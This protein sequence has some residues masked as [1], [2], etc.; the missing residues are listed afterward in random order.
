MTE[1]G[2]ASKR[3]CSV[4][5]VGSVGSWVYQMEI[6]GGSVPREV[7]PMIHASKPGDDPAAHAPAQGDAVLPTQEEEEQRRF[8]MSRSL[9]ASPDTPVQATKKRRYSATLFIERDMKKHQKETTTAQGESHRPTV[10]G[11]PAAAPLHAGPEG[12]DVDTE[13]AN[14]PRALKRPGKRSR[15]AQPAAG[16]KEDAP[17]KAPLPQLHGD[18]DSVA[19]EMSAWT[20][21]EIQR[22]LDDLDEREAQTSPV[23]PGTR[24]A[25]RFQPRV[26]AR[27]YPERHP[28]QGDPVAGPPG[29][30]AM[31][32]D[33]AQ[34]QEDEEWV[35]VVYRRVPASVING[36]VPQR[37]IGVI[38][39]E[40]DEEKEYFYGAT[41]DDSDADGFDDDDENGMS[42][43]FVTGPTSHRLFVAK[44]NSPHGQT[45]SAVTNPPATAEDYY[46]AD[47][48]EDEVS[49]D[50]EHGLNPYQYRANASDDEEFDDGDDEFNTFSGD[51]EDGGVVAGDNDEDALRKIRTYL[52]RHHGRGL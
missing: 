51:E 39:F 49:S 33:A 25:L 10:P 42:T 44:S 24:D 5:S 27:R 31:A 7:R 35:E 14:E 40:D 20:V 38:V 2:D 17:P 13:A 47:Y 34:G 15:I 16:A 18:I 29:G 4:G 23:R 8:Y 43:P 26:P 19:A 21:S 22:N 6:S 1:L 36:T 9:V 46:G 12:M 3:H 28:Q 41:E 37:D 11:E 48:P 50:D 30:D 45:R 32:V 52:A